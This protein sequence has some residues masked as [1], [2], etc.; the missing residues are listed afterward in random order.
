MYGYSLRFLAD[1]HYDQ[2]K[3]RVDF[4]EYLLNPQQVELGRYSQPEVRVTDDMKDII[5]STLHGSKVYFL[6]T[7][8]GALATS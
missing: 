1:I 3:P 4:T 6:I 5:P 8:S 2:A 7:T